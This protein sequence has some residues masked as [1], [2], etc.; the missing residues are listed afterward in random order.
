MKTMP[1]LALLLVLLLPAV[2]FAGIQHSRDVPALGDAGLIT[3][4]VA[5]VGAGVVAIR[6]RKR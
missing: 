6:R 4:G 5:L 2:L 3:L 1:K